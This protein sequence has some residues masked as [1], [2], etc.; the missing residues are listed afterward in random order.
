MR[1]IWSVMHIKGFR[2]TAFLVSPNTLQAQLVVLAWS[3]L[4]SPI[5]AQEAL[6][7]PPVWRLVSPKWKVP[8]G[9]LSTED[10]AVYSV[11]GTFAVASLFFAVSG[12]TRSLHTSRTY[13]VVQYLGAWCA[14]CLMLSTASVAYCMPPLTLCT[15]MA[16]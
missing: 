14:Q 7:P 15:C 5:L 13:H 11:L 3:I 9:D 8:D 4:V 10:I 1:D 16:P 2:L 12:V 6:P